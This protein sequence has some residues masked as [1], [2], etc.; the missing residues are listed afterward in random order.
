MYSSVRDWVSRRFTAFD[1]SARRTSWAV[2]RLRQI[3]R[4]LKLALNWSSATGSSA[5]ETVLSALTDEVVGIDIL[6]WCVR[7][8]EETEVLAQLDAVLREAASVW[9]IGLDET[10]APELQRRTDETVTRLV[11]SAAAANSRPSRHLAAAWSALYG[12][13]PDPSTAYREAVKAVEAAAHLIV[14]PDNSAATLGQMIGALR[15]A[16]QKWQVTLKPDGG[17]DPV[18]LAVGMMQLLWKSQLDRHGSGHVDAPFAMNQDE[19]EAALHVA[20]SLV[21]LFDSGTIRRVT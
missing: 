14:I 20:A 8:E 17:L 9:T 19:A 2:E 10:G 21:H 12:T 3:E 7:H 6:D 18:G 15:D 5:V 4:E 11:Q 13:H 16:P 1:Y